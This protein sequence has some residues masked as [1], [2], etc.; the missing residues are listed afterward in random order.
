MAKDVQHC[1]GFYFDDVCPSR[2]NHDPADVRLDRDGFMRE[3][4]YICKTCGLNPADNYNFCRH[5]VENS[6]MFSNDNWKPHNGK[7]IIVTNFQ[8]KDEAA[9][10]VRA[11]FSASG[12]RRYLKKANN[13]T[14]Y[15]VNTDDGH[16]I[17]VKNG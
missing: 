13:P 1:D 7:T 8:V 10:T 4:R 9:H 17:G 12:V 11:F 16:L 3:P 6:K 14:L 15:G 2:G 5:C